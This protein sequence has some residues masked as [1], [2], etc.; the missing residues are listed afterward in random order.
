MAALHLEWENM[1]WEPIAG[2]IS[3]KVLTDGTK[4]NCTTLKMNKGICAVIK[5]AR[6]LPPCRPEPTLGKP[7]AVPACLMD[8]ASME[9][10]I[11]TGNRMPYAHIF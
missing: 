10:Q 6:V 5:E 7:A 8:F 11:L 3:P 9:P 4:I 2:Q 1:L